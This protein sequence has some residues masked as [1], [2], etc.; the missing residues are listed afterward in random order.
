MEVSG[1]KKFII[2]KMGNIKYPVI[3]GIPILIRS[4]AIAI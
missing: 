4:E 2:S 3:D 1:D